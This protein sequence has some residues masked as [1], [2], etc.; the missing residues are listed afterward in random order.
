MEDNFMASKT[1]DFATMVSIISGRK[2]T[3][4]ESIYNA[5]AFLT[6]NK[7]PTNQLTKTL[8]SAKKHILKSYP[9]LEDIGIDVVIN[10]KKE[11]QDFIESLSKIFG[12]E[13]TLTPM[14]ENE[15]EL[16]STKKFKEL[17]R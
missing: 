15:Y 3:N 1:F 13:F 4:L 16:N 12:N 7:I 9:E 8:D 5:L 17:I 2:F 10:D 6:E 11:A 14:A